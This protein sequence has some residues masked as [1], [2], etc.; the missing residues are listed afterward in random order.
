MSSLAASGTS[1]GHRSLPPLRASHVR[2]CALP[3]WYRTLPMLRKRS[4]RTVVVP[5]PAAFLRYLREDGI[6]LP[7]APDGVILDSNDPRF[8][9]A[10]GWSS[11]EEEEEGEEEEGEEGGGLVVSVEE[12]K[13]KVYCFPALEQRLREAIEELGGAVFP[14]LD[15]S[16]PRDAGFLR[17]GSLKC[18][19]PGDIF[20]LLKGSDF[21]AHDLTHAFDACGDEAVAAVEEEGREGGSG[22]AAPA[23]AGGSGSSSI[24]NTAISTSAAGSGASKSALSSSPSYVHH[25]VLRSW[26]NLY[27]SQEFR[28]IVVHGRLVGISQRHCDRR[29]PA[30]SKDGRMAVVEA[31]IA[32]FFE[33][34]LRPSLSSGEHAADASCYTFDAYLSRS[35]KVTLIDLGVFHPGTSDL[36][37]FSWREVADMVAAGDGGGRDDGSLPPKVE[38]R[39]VHSEADALPSQLA[40]HRVPADFVGDPEAFIENFADAF[41]AGKIL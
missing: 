2:L 9:A 18:E 36:K 35:D 4:V 23:I 30:L 17:G 33:T 31:K 12:E 27:P 21:V 3:T 41:R 24:T 15:W 14:K 38:V 13:K 20:L 22:A 5:A 29:F 34:V 26:C 8:E 25:I 11:S 10:S 1:S 19:T 6:M 40:V 28:C 7:E 32:A 16:A 37:L 39:F